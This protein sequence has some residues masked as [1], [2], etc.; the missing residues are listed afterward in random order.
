VAGLAVTE[1]IAAETGVTPELRHPNDVL[2]GGRKVAG[3]LAEARDE[4]VVVGIGINANLTEGQLPVEVDRPATS[5]LVESGEPV[6][7]ARLLASLLER[8]EWR[9]DDWISEAGRA[10]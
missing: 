5:L 8:L 7:R 3:V 6:D 10:R 4:R 9:Y 1:A 2:I